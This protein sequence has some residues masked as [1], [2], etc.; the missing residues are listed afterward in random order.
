MVHTCMHLH[1]NRWHVY[2]QAHNVML[3]RGVCLGVFVLC[4]LHSCVFNENVKVTSF[5][6][7]ENKTYSYLMAKGENIVIFCSVCEIQNTVS[8]YGGLYE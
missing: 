6:Q 8:Y 1:K 7:T 4:A 5:Q 3:F 2:T